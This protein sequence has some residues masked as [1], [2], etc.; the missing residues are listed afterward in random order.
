MADLHHCV[1]ADD[2]DVVEQGSRHCRGSDCYLGTSTRGFSQLCP[3]EPRSGEDLGPV[4]PSSDFGT[5][6]G[7]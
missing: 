3:A 4:S 7:R 2:V 5:G 6:L 1:D